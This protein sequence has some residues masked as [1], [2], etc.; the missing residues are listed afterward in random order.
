[1]MAVPRLDD[2]LSRK[3]RAL[4]PDKVGKIAYVIIPEVLFLRDNA[5]GGN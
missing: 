3:I 2:S 4:L 1:M 5:E